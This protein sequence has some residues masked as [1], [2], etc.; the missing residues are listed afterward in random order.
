MFPAE[1]HE[2]AAIDRASPFTRFRTITVPLLRPHEPVSGG[3]A[4]HQRVAAVRRGL[5]DHAGGGPLRATTVIVYYLWDPCVR[6]V[7]RRVR[8]GDGHALFVVILLIT[9]VQFRLA[10][11]HV[12]PMTRNFSPHLRRR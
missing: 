9:A 5:R 3:L 6:A 10:R 2:A 8:R 1:L 11:K 7:R 4:D 12:H